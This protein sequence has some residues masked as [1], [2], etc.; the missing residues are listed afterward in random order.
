MERGG[1]IL[2][3]EDDRDLSALICELLQIEGYR[4]E[5]VY[6][7]RAAS[8]RVTENPPD[9]VILDLMIPE[10]SGF[11]VCQQLK[12]SRL[13]N[14]IPVLMLTAASAPKSRQNGL[15]VGADH[16]LLKPFAPDH[17]LAVLRDALQHGLEVGRGHTSVMLRLQSDSQH[18][19]QLNDLLSELLTLTPMSEDQ[20]W[21]LRYAALEMIE[22]AAEWGNRRQK[23]LVVALN[24]EVREDSVKFT[25]TDE[26]PGFDPTNIPHAASGEDPIAHMEIRKKLG[27]RDGGFGILTAR[28]FVD[29]FTYSPSGNQVT[30]VAYFNSRRVSEST[31]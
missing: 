16:Y 29:E 31:P 6:D 23:D 8:R 27:L 5:A 17:L 26:G 13:T 4:A 18:R 3:V 11:E 25:I 10:L 9:A 1:R 30:M 28:G 21:R 7:G 19:E 20:I 24:Y 22:N 14:R 15:S 12:F 2:V